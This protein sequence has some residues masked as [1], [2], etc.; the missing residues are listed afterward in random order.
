MKAPSE[1]PAVREPLIRVRGVNQYYGTGAL[2]KQVL[3]EVTAD[4]HPGEIVILTGPSG[5]GKTTFLTLCGALRTVEEGSLQ[6]LGTELRSAGP[7]TLI[8]V[9][10]NIGFI[11]QQHNLIRA[12][13]ACQNVEVA[14]QLE[15]GIPR[16][17]LRRRARAMLGA[18][19][20]EHHADAYPD[21]L[22]GGEKQRVSIARA[23]ARH[24][25]VVLADEP[26]AALDRKGGREVV[27]LLRQLARSQECATLL[28]TH[29][30]RILDV[31]DRI[32]SLEDGRIVSFAVGLTAHTGHLLSAL[33]Q[34]NRRGDLLRHVDELSTTRF[35]ET[36]DQV[37][38][39]FVQ[40]VQVLE[41]GN[42]EVVQAL[43]DQVLEAVTCKIRDLLHAD[44]A[45]LFLVD[46][47]RGRLESRIAHGEGGRPLQIE[48][49]IRTGIAGRV[50]TTG[51]A[52]NVADPYAHP[53][54]NPDVDRQTGYLTRS[55]LCL[56]LLDRRGE[57][58]AVA[59]LLNKEGGGPF[60]AEDER[61][62]R[63]FAEP[64]GVI[65][66]SC[67]RLTRRP[68]VPDSP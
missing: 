37:T 59:Q 34:L 21:R 23:L 17:E 22:S 45:T 28:V 54:F 55:I 39:E 36:L 8:R 47:E 13:T 64:L 15:R 35:L 67:V 20:V 44:R 31:A 24:P 6:I 43:F 48:I 25:A 19:G 18:V 12:L 65:L 2:R 63:E 49:P 1:R 10:R 42:Q 5:S 52:L 57:V 7:E 62:F 46:R 29:D 4:I 3:Y 30:S 16:Q 68:S 60:S 32:L 40:C 56:P 50:A 14:L 61:T 33:A 58:F 41:L 38:R 51:E 26:T 11:F 9:R 27:D 66:E 53:E